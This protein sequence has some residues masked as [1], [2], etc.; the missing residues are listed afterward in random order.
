MRCS[1]ND[2][3]LHF[4]AQL[5]KVRAVTGHSDDKRPVSFRIFLRFPERFRI[6]YIELN[7]IDIQIHK[8]SDYG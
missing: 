5:G 1:L 7:V 8:G 6:N 2:I 4:L 3:I